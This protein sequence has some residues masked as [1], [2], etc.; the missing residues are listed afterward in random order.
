M[1][2]TETTQEQWRKVIGTSPSR[3][4]GSNLPVEMV[5]WWEAVEFCEKVG[6]VLPTE[7]QWEYACRA[8][9][10]TPFSFGSTIS[11]SQAN[12][13]DGSAPKGGSRGKTTDVRSF[14]A[15]TWGL[16]DMHGNVWEWCSDG[17]GH[18]PIGTLSSPVRDPKGFDGWA[19]HVLRGGSWFNRPEDLR[20]ANRRE[21]SARGIGGYFGFRVSRI[22]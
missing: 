21:G 22:P 2:E 14:S 3:H 4:S 16:Y 12:Y 8:G 9:T 1:A 13:Y 18:Y 20:A 5:S 7:S 11:R 19:S 15:N 6:G 10:T 17:F